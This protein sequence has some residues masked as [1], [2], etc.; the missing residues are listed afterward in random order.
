MSDINL[1]LRKLGYGA[2]VTAVNDNENGN[3]IK[4][5]KKWNRRRLVFLKHLI[6]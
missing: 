1:N 3:L 5:L 6:R 4:M 2:G